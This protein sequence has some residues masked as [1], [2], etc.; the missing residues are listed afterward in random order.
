MR[1]KKNTTTSENASASQAT[2][3]EPNQII[4]VYV[5]DYH[6]ELPQLG[7]VL[8]VTS[9]EVELEWLTGCYS[10]IDHQPVD[11]LSIAHV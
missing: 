6:D 4:A 2:S 10:G 9:D 11:I 8:E 1:G 3:L 5:A 7:R